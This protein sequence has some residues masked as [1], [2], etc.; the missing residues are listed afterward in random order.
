VI[1]VAMLRLWAKL[2][3][4]DI[5]PQPQVNATDGQAQYNAAAMGITNVPIGQ[6]STEFPAKLER[7]LASDPAQRIRNGAERACVALLCAACSGNT[8]RLADIG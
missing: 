1:A 4:L 8:G 2:S 6:A 3:L 7:V 5:G